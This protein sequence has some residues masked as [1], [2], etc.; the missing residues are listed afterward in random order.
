MRHSRVTRRRYNSE[1]L[2]YV[3]FSSL[4]FPS[5]SRCKVEVMCIILPKKP[6]AVLTL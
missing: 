4:D 3:F 2:I 1:L 5:S 6:I